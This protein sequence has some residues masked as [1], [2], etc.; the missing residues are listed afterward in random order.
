M[1]ADIK[2]IEE[3][4]QKISNLSLDEEKS[5]KILELVGQFEIEAKN[6][7][8]GKKLR[9]ILLDVSAINVRAGSLVFDYSESC[10]LLS[11]MV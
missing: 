1:P 10:G 9:K 4:R 5:K 3:L 6:K 11:K 8:D 7:R 2:T